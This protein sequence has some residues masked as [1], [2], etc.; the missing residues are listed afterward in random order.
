MVVDDDLELLPVTSDQA[1]VPVSSQGSREDPSTLLLGTYILI[2]LASFSAVVLPSMIPILGQTMAVGT[3][4]FP[5]QRH[6]GI[7]SQFA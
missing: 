1:F 7:S 2:P 3:V 5:F 4:P 6:L